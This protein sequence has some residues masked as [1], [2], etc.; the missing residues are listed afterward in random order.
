MPGNHHKERWHSNGCLL[1][2]RGGHHGN[3]HKEGLHPSIGCAPLFSHGICCPLC[4]ADELKCASHGIVEITDLQDEAI[5]VKAMAPLEAHITAY[6]TAWHLKPSKG[7][8]EL[9]TPPKQ[10]PPSGGT[11][12]HLQVDLGDLINHELQQLVEELHQEITQ[13]EMNAP[14]SSP[15]PSKWACPLGSR[16]P[17]EDDQEVTFPGEGRWGP[18]RQPTPAAEQPAGGRVHSGSPQ[19]APCP[20]LAGSDMG[21]LITALTLGLHVGT[22]K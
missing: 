11:P 21:Q 14:L 4:T 9:H 17:K 12:H 15:P 5:M 22:P 1:Y 3:L 13:C 19:Q 16:E 18:L 7:D 2:F 20:A 6:M 10:T 8:G